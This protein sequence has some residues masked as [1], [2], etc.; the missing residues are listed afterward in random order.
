[1][2]AAQF[3][4]GNVV[5]RE[6]M[7]HDSAASTRFYTETFGWKANV[8]NMGT[9]N[10]TMFMMGQ[11]P[12]AGMM[13]MPQGE[14]P[15]FW[16]SSI[17]VENVDATKA[18]VEAAGG[19]TVAGPMDIPNMGRYCM[20]MDPQGAAFSV[21]HAANGDG[22]SAQPTAGNFCWE[23]LN[24]SNVAEALAFYTKVLPWTASTFAPTGT[25]NFAAAG[26]DIAS[27]M[28]TQPGQPASWLSYVVV[29]ALADAQARVE[30]QGGG[31][32][33]PAHPVPTVGTICVM[34]DNVG[35]VIGLMEPATR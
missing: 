30:R 13:E 3:R 23:H 7:T 1:M 29:D 8:M 24:A 6:L 9:Q 34:R 12:V 2:A 18:A 14:M 20:F 33:M 5:W 4:Y 21:W 32:L 17:S 25:N 31:I 26:C 10:Y 35:A 28:P 15:A 19:K 16:C 27:V 11:T 22:D